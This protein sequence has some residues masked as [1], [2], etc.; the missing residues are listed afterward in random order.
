M[1]T[2]NIHENFMSRAIHLA[3]KGRGKVSPNPMVGCV[4]VKNGKIIG[5]GFHKKFGGDHAEV[6]AF[7]NCTDDPTDAS[8]YVTLEPCSHFGKTGPCCNAIIENGIRDVY[9]SM[10]DPN[11]QVNGNGIDFLKNSGIN[12]ECNILKNESKELNKGYINW[13]KTKKPLVIGKMAQDSNGYIA[14]SGSK[15]WITGHSSKQNSHQL[16]SEVDAI[17]VGK[18]TVLIDN[19]E[20]TVREVIGS[21]PKRIVLDT[22]RT[23]PYNF[24]LLKDEEADTIIMCSNK[25]FQNSETSHCKYITVNEINEKLDL[26]DVLIKLGELGITSLLVE[27]GATTIKSFLDVELIEKFYLYTSSLS[28]NE[29]DIKNP[30]SI[31]DNWIVQ[32]EK[33]LDDDHLVVLNKRVECLQEL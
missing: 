6:D 10:S 18:N 13:I 2:Y 21:N 31:N 26:N 33:F 23:L 15:I 28:K 7:K 16:R 1:N 8:L 17:L 32:N 20:L 14:K 3:K 22:N 27:G 9:I 11:K 30:F 12:V 29:L 4:I 24:K 25:K 19:P 5:E